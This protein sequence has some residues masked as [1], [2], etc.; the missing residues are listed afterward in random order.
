VS[1]SW[2][3]IARVSRWEFKNSLSWKWDVWERHGGRDFLVKGEGRKREEEERGKSGKES[4]Q[5]AL[6]TRKPKPLSVLP[7]ELRPRYEERTPA[8]K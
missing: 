4:S 3:A 5:G 2:V 8:V 7:G 6:A 1:F